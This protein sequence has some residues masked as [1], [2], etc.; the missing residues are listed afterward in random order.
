M[1]D[2]EKSCDSKLMSGYCDH[3]IPS[4]INTYQYKQNIILKVQNELIY[5]WSARYEV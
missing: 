4:I 3:I 5:Q 2:C 1:K